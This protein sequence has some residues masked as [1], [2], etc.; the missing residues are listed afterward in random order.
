[1]VDRALAY[2]AKDEFENATESFV[3]DRTKGGDNNPN[4][5]IILQSY[6]GSYESFREGVLG[7]YSPLNVKDAYRQ[8]ASSRRLHCVRSTLRHMSLWL[9][10]QLGCGGRF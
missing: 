4:T 5:M 8:R 6:H 10:R 9:G 7:F 1:M 2:A 3:S